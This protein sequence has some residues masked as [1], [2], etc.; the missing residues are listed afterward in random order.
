MAYSVMTLL[1]AGASL[2]FA[3][4]SP[5]DAAADPS[6]P[7]TAK[8]ELS[9]PFDASKGSW[10]PVEF[11]PNNSFVRS[12]EMKLEPD[13]AFDNTAVNAW[14]LYCVDATTGLDTAWVS[15]SQGDY[16]DW[17]GLR[18]CQKGGFVTGFHALVLQ[19]NSLFSDDVAVQ[20]WQVECDY[21]LEILGG[22]TGRSTPTGE[23]GS[24]V[25]CP[26]DS[27]VCG[28]Q[29]RVE[30]SQLTDDD[31]AVDDVALFCCETPQSPQS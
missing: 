6:R 29:T 26:P 15:S 14:K 10:G 30:K 24:W 11:C 9:N 25:Q 2:S 8:L 18:V 5:P 3:L 4:P 22:E 20:D 21:G 17:L 7:H 19:T 28:I 13:G 23:W 31:T 12:Y 27:A 1:L 16:G